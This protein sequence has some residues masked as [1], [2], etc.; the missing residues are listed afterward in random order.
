MEYTHRGGGGVISRASLPEFR[1]AT[2]LLCGLQEVTSFLSSKMS[3]FVK[4][5]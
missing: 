1:S 2:Y 4:W 3:S 5:G